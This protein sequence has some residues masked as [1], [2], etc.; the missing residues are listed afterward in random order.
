MDTPSLNL[1]GWLYKGMRMHPCKPCGGFVW[2]EQY[3]GDFHFK[4]TQLHYCLSCHFKQM[5]PAH[6]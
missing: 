3:L 6:V 1:E 2:H 4:G 5:R